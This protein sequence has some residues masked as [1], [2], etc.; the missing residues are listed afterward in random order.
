MKIACEDHVKIGRMIQVNKLYE[1]KLYELSEDVFL[2]NGGVVLK[3][4]DDVDSEEL[5]DDWEE[6]MKQN[7]TGA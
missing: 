1:I 5:F 3:A 6:A 2:E 4:E 7:D